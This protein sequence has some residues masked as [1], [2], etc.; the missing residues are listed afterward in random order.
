MQGGEG[1]L[2]VFVQRIKQRDRGGEPAN[3]LLCHSRLTFGSI[4]QNVL[5]HLDRRAQADATRGLGQCAK[6]VQQD[7]EMGGQERVEINEGFAIEINAVDA[8]I[9][10]LGVLAQLL[11]RLIEQSAQL[12]FSC[13]RLA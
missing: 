12:D 3:G 2:D 1:A 9:D 10:E 5:H 13:G 8:G 11:T 6:Q 7:V 4:D